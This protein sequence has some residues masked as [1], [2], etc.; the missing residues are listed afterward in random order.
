MH[1]QSFHGVTDRGPLHFGVET[2]PL[3]HFQG[4]VGLDV[5]VTNSFV[6]FDDGNFGI[7]NYRANE[8]LAAARNNEIDI[9]LQLQQLV[10]QSVIFMLHNLHGVLRHARLGAGLAQ[11]R[12]D[13]LIGMMRFAAAA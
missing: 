2:N 11:H 4:R 13:R 1:Q 8:I 12:A 9:L 5:N 3:G 6:V 7:R 10:D